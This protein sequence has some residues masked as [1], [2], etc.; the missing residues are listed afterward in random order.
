M[1]DMA[2]AYGVL[3][4]GGHRAEINPLLTVTDFQGNILYQ[5][6]CALDPKNC[7]FPQVVPEGVAYQVT[8]VLKDNVARTPA[9]GPFSVLN[10]PNQE[11]AVKT[12]TTNNLRDN[13]TIGYTSNRLVATW[14]GNN[15]NTDELCCLWDYWSLTDLERYHA[16]T[17]GSRPSPCFSPTR[18]DYF[19][20]KLFY[21][22][23]RS[24]SRRTTSSSAM[25]PNS[26]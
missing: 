11:V 15:D 3:A 16:N 4:T 26:F 22:P 21:P 14:V 7:H 17:V 18:H 24:A 5:N 8:H 6:D 2:K 23:R 13:W 20:K 1:L 9:F 12:G 19:I 25:Q 10:I